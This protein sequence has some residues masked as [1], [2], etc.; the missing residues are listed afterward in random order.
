MATEV[1]RE[2]V[3]DAGHVPTDAVAQELARAT[4]EFR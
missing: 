1:T 2:A 3:D 4:D